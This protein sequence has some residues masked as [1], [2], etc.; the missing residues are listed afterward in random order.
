MA[1]DGPDWPT[2]LSRR[3]IEP[4]ELL[5]IDSLPEEAVPAFE[6]ALQTVCVTVAYFPTTARWR[7]AASAGWRR[8]D[9]WPMS[10]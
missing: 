5:V 9:A 7:R 10:A 8:S 3:R 6:A 1:S 2:P 4:L